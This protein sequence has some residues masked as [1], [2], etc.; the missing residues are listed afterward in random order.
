MNG[1]YLRGEIIKVSTVAEDMYTQHV[2]AVYDLPMEQ[3]TRFTL[4][5]NLRPI[6]YKPWQIG[7][8]YGPSGCGKTSLLGL[9]GTPVEPDF[10]PAKALV[11]CFDWMPP[12]DVCKLLAHVGLASVPSWLRPY[13][14]LSNGEQYMA[15]LAY[16]LAKGGGC[17]VLDE[18]TSVVDR[19]VAK[20]MANSLQ[21]HVR[22]TGKQVV[23]ASCHEDIIEW[24]QPDWTY[25]PD[26]LRGVLEIGDGLRQGRPSLAL[27]PY[28]TTYHSW[29]IF[30]AHHYMSDTLNK[31]FTHLVFT[32]D[33][34]PV[35]LCAYVAMPSGTIKRAYR[36][37]RTVVLPDYQGLGIGKGVSDFTAGLL[38]GRGCRVFT[39]TVNPAL[40]EYRDGSTK[41]RPTSKN[42]KARNDDKG[43]NKWKQYARQSYCHEYIGEGV[44][45]HNELI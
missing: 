41:W 27:Q 30:K 38:K 42:G 34:K 17:T 9:F 20:A 13:Q 22:A 16:A 10:D 14:A 45:G 29:H 39:K 33:G 11:S 7:V 23:I 5:Y 24:L 2:S 36:L 3:A 8:I 1:N 4:P 37:A 44:D 6:L 18:F 28:R 32:L 15:R 43:R 19:N 12:Q 31:S 40:G 21:R 35:A 26:N 25:T